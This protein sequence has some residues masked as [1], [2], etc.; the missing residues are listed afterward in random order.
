M[1]AVIHARAL[2][3]VV[4]ADLLARVLT[5]SVRG[6]LFRAV[7]GFGQPASSRGLAAIAALV[8]PALN[9]WGARRWYSA[10]RWT[11]FAEPD[12]F[13]GRVEANVLA[14]AGRFRGLPWSA[15]E[16]HHLS[17][18]LGS[19]E[20]SAA[21]APVELGGVDAFISH[22]WSDDGDAKFMALSR[23]ATEFEQHAGRE[24]V[25]WLDKACI[26][27]DDIDASLLG[28]PIYVS[29]C[30]RLLVLDGPTYSTRLWCIMEIFCF[31]VLGGSQNDIEVL[32]L[33]APTPGRKVPVASL[34]PGAPPSPPSP[35]PPTRRNASTAPTETRGAT[36]LA[37]PPLG[38]TRRGAS[39]VARNFCARRALCFHARDRE[40]LLGAIEAAYGDTEPFDAAVRNLL[41]SSAHESSSACSG[42]S[43]GQAGASG[44]GGDGGRGQRRWK[45]SIARYGDES[46]PP[47]TS[48]A[49]LNHSRALTSMH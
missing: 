31:V 40:R 3:R 9:G 20:L 4:G 27:Q 16:A 35:P 36:R 47:F 24:P 8:T 45:T 17:S 18:S 1:M 26:D 37:T 42:D 39:E 19:A 5:P 12:W 21:A 25:L 48:I 13:R 43:G 29:G 14:A 41:D 10:L 49:H 44:S 11:G 32:P 15:L 46:K 23:W 2:I 7:G 30:T 22:S 38:Y 34:A 33:G 28:L 6:R